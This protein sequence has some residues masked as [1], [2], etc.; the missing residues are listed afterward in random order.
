M[1]TSSVNHQIESVL[2]SYNTIMSVAEVHGTLSGMLCADIGAE[3]DRWLAEVFDD[4]AGDING[5]DRMI[6]VAFFDETRNWMDGTYFDFE[7]A[8][9]DDDT[10]LNQRTAA[11]S[12]WC[13][14]F[15]FGFGLSFG[16]QQDHWPSDCKEILRDIAEISR[17]DTEE[18]SE[19]N[20][21]AFMEL[22]EY[23]RVGIQL[24]HSELQSTSEKPPVLH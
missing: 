12:D 17:I 21:E 5:E 3:I 10:P 15:L 23:L 13:R 19:E 2:L 1:A 8:L 6:L 16:S 7:I 11:L 9:P 18:E 20:E 22:N 4:E 14:G 24:I